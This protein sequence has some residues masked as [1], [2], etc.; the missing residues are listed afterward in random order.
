MSANSVDAEASAALVEAVVRRSGSSF[1]WGMRILPPERRRAMYAVYAFCRTVDDIADEPGDRDLRQAQLEAWRGEL[2]RLYGDG[3]PRDP[4]ARALLPAIRRYDLPRREFEAVI[5]GMEMD[6]HGRNVAPPMAT[7]RL[8]CRRVAGAVGLLSIRCF[9]AEEPEAEDAAIALGEA[10]QFT[11]ILR[12]LGEDA[13][14]G[15]LY[16]PVELLERHGVVARAPDAVLDDP[17]LPGVCRELATLARDRYAEAGS[18]IARCSRQRMKPAILMS[19]RYEALLDRLEAAGWREPRRRVSLPR[20]R[21]LL[22]LRH[23]LP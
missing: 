15:R 22:L 1:L 19:A 2:E 21:S 4:I 6:L 7:L 8:Y 3:E 16:L 10:L 11:N 13:D 12:D 9:G 18:L 5:A 23:L 20:W 14:S 17:R